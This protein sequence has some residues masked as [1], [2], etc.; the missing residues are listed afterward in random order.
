MAR[1]AI[2]ARAPRAIVEAMALPRS[3]GAAQTTPIAGD[4]EANLAQHVE[5]MRTAAT[6]DARILVFP[7][8]SLTGYELALADRLAFSEN[9]TRLGPLIEAAAQHAM[10]AVVGAPV[11]IDAQLYI[12]AFAVMPDRSLALYT[13]P[14]LGAFSR[15]EIP[16]GVIPPAEDTIFQ[17]GT[18]DPLIRWA[19]ET[20]AVAVCA[21]ALQ[22]VHAQRAAERGAT[23][24][25]TSHFSIP[26][27]VDFRAAVLSSYAKRHG[28]VTVFANYGAPT[29]GLPASGKS[30]VW[31]QAGEL[32]GRLAATGAGV[33]VAREANSGWRADAIMLE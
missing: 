5:L 23:S 10:V 33:L 21:A 13:K 7:E 29:A 1:T 18:R 25:L 14:Y 9:D 30:A 27:D 2:D 11:R 24:Y 6:L 31:S 15:R 3:I 20:A 28:M 32:I 8:L 4:V 19:G 12:G 17:C 16:E 22:P 26:V